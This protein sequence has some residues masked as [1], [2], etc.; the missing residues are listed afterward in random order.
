M[1]KRLRAFNV[2][3]RFERDFPTSSLRVRSVKSATKE[4]AYVV[5]SLPPLN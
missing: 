2:S 4:A 1:G 3:F 5:D